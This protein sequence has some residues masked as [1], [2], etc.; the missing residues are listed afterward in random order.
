MKQEQIKTDN[1]DKVIRGLGNELINKYDIENTV[2]CGSNG[3]YDDNETHIRNLSHLVVITSIEI[4]RY[5]QTQNIEILGRMGEDLLSQKDVRGFY[6]MREKSG[7]DECNGVIGYAWLIEALVYLTKTLKDRRFVEEAGR[8]AKLHHFNSK[9]GLWGRPGYGDDVNALD[10]TLNHQLWYA[11]SLCE[12]NEILADSGIKKELD[13]F[14]K[15]LYTNFLT[16]KSGR[17]SH[18][19]Y[20]RISFSESLKYKIKLLIDRINEKAGR[21]SMAYKEEGYHLFNIMALARIYYH[22]PQWS[23]FD[24]DKFD[25]AIGYINGSHFQKGLLDNKIGLDKSFVNGISEESE[26]KV[27]IY[28]YPYN[29]PGFEILYIN[30]IMP[31]KIEKTVVK[32]CME[33]QIQLTM[34]KKLN[35]F[36]LMCHD[37]NTI[38]YRIYEYY[39]YLEIIS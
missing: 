9:I 4:I 25:A 35:Q 19:I 16:A 30:K 28:G 5:G 39:R 37:K 18:S 24:S 6:K 1:I 31:C 7:K 32:E 14:Q 2:L 22:Y 36:G 20:R 34:D 13:G 10:Y 12:L 26:K 21:P 33:K 27:N 38:N 15:N 17:I 29:V 11:A 3:P 23:F 8:L